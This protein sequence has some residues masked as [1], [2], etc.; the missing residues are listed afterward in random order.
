MR[1]GGAM[2]VPHEVRRERKPR[3]VEAAAL[4]LAAAAAAV[5]VAW[6]PDA[7]ALDALACIRFYLAQGCLP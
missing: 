2:S 1:E 3:A 4:A 6:L 7:Q 5:L